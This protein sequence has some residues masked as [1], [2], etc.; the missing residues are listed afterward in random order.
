MSTAQLSYPARGSVD[1]LGE[2]LRARP[3]APYLLGA[4]LLVLLL[5][6]A[7]EHGAVASGPNARIQVALSAVAAFAA[8]AWLWTGTLRLAAP[9]AAYVGV[10]LLAGF[11]VWSGV[12]LIWSVSPEGTWTELNHGL[13]YVLVLC[14]AISLGSS[15]RRSVELVAEGFLVVVLAVAVYALGQKVVPGLYLHDVSTLNQNELL[16]R[17]QDPLGYWNALALFVLLGL[18]IALSLAVDRDRPVRQRLTGLCSVVLIALVIAFTYSRGGVLAAVVAIA[19][20][21]ALSGVRLR[22]LMWL[23]AAMLAALPA[24]LFGLL[25]HSLTTSTSLSARESAGA[26]LGAIL[27]VSLAGLVSAGHWLARRERAAHV[28]PERASGITRLLFALV[29]VAIIAG[30]LAITVSSRG[31]TGTLSHE[32]KTF[33]NTHEASISSPSR[34]FAADSA[35][36]WVWWKEAVGA[37]S[38]RPITG[39]GAGSFPVVHLLYRRDTLSVQQPHSVPLQFLAETGIV[40]AALAIAAFALLLTV[41]VKAVR[42]R[43]PGGERVLAAALLAAAAAYAIH[44]F[45]DWDWDIPAVTMPALVLLG[46]LLGSA[47]G[48]RKPRV[49]GLGI[50]A[51]GLVAATLLMC[52]FALSAA[53]PSLAGS[54]ANSALVAAASDSAGSLQRAQAGAALATSLDPLSDVGLRVEATIATRRGE[55]ALARRDLL[56]AVARD[57]SDAIAWQTLVFVELGLGD[58]SDAMR[59]ADRALLLDPKNA[60]SVE[61]ATGLSQRASF[62]AEPPRDSPTA[63]QTPLP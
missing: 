56:A 37:W 36:R 42:A 58:I 61:L 21:L 30:L 24:M 7:F 17:L 32:W 9:R 44:T 51:V 57:P 31:L 41:A 5:Y 54:K 1:A 14:L 20:A 28:S 33:T 63:A 11:A 18:P 27:I 25:D 34:L 3:R 52:A 62:D 22:A 49:A 53:V 10:A 38:D 39:W 12:S 23:A 47:A 4:A 59:A 6:A 13:E 60:F 2:R 46:V 29:G 48:P 50:R 40:G 19:V 35:N 55:Y 26:A 45:Y 8:G 43:A 15:L 16:S